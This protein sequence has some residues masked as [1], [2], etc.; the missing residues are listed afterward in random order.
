M[1]RNAPLRP[2][3]FIANIGP[4]PR[5]LGFTGT[6]SQH[7]DRRIIGEYGLPLEDMFFEG[8]GQGFQK[9]R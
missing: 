7:L 9:R 4:K 8:V 3:T 6:W 2:G 5:G 1:R